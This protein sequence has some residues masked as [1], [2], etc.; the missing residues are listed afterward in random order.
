M[1]LLFSLCLFIVTNFSFA[2][3]GVF[4]NNEELPQYTLGRFEVQL[5]NDDINSL[6][7]PTDPNLIQLYNTYGPPYQKS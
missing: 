2:V 5:S 1:K 3:E 4:G 7:S 6:T